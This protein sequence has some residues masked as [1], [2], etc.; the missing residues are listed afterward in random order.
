MTQAKL[1]CLSECS[2]S[3]LASF[4]SRS[5]TCLKCRLFPRSRVFGPVELQLQLLVDKLAPHVAFRWIGFAIL[6]VMYGAWVYLR[7]GWFIVTY[8]LGIFLLNQ[9]VGFVTPLEDPSA[10]DGR[11]LLPVSVSKSGLGGSCGLQAC[12]WGW[13]QFV[14]RVAACCRLSYAFRVCLHGERCCDLRLRLRI[15]DCCCT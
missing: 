12:R 7:P 5:C 15:C 10:T 9:L 3:H 14:H 1:C 2:P 8:G 11:P 13:L 6:L 4:D